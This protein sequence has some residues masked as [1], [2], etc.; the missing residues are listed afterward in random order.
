[1]IILAPVLVSVLLMFLLLL[2]SPFLLKFLLLIFLPLPLLTSWLLIFPGCSTLY[3]FHMCLSLL[4]YLSIV[5]HVLLF[6]VLACSFLPF[7]C[8][9]WNL[10]AISFA[11][12]ESRCPQH[13]PATFK[14]DPDFNI[15]NVEAWKNERWTWA[16]RMW[17]F[18]SRII[19][20]L[21]SPKHPLPRKSPSK[22][23]FTYE[24]RLWV[25][26]WNSDCEIAT[27]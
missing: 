24:V 10:F 5:M 17:Y 18:G 1:M 12:V 19:S 21:A 7:F 15:V 3:S 22:K 25:W 6:G 14:K 27:N 13:V 8:L 2:I 11:D 16:L 26:G 20:G 4:L 23:I 9:F